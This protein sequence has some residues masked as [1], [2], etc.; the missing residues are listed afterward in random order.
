[1]V[2]I[3]LGAALNA[4][5]WEAIKGARRSALLD[6]SPALCLGV[7]LPLIVLL[8]P[9]GLVGL[10]HRNLGDLSDRWRRQPRAC[11]RSSRWIAP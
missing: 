8:V 2:G 4:V 9:F 5:T 10:G 11:S 1:M 3:E 7:G 6:W